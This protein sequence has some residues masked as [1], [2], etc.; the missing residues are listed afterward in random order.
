MSVLMA[1]FV[2]HFNDNF[3]VVIVANNDIDQIILNT[4]VMTVTSESTSDINRLK[5]KE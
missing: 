3:I 5:P 4:T 1:F 2:R